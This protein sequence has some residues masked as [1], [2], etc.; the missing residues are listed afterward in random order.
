MCHIVVP[1]NH[2]INWIKDKICKIK[3]TVIAIL[4]L[5]R[6]VSATHC[7]VSVTLT[8][9]SILVE[10]TQGS[11]RGAKPAECLRTKEV[12]LAGLQQQRAPLEV[13][14]HLTQLL[15]T[16]IGPSTHKHWSPH[17]QII[18]TGGAGKSKRQNGDRGSS[19]LCDANVRLQ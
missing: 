6:Y 15:Q 14:I 18:Q 8:V 10:V 3:I 19:T 5:T 17:H 16:P 2:L 12:G 13:Y 7:I 11:Q 1:Q 4:H 9:E